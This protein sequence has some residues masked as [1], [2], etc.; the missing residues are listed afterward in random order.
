M[1]KLLLKKGAHVNAVNRF[2]VTPI[3]EP[4]MTNNLEFIKLLVD[5]KADPYIKVRL[6]IMLIKNVLLTVFIGYKD[7]HAFKIYVFLLL[8]P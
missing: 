7:S 3:L 6:S 1:A 2:G 4:V 8:D 5:H